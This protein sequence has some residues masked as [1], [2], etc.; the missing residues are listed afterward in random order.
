MSEHGKVFLDTNILVYSQD[1]HSRSKQRRARTLLRDVQDGGNGVI[2]TQVLQE[3]FVTATRKLEI[4]PIVAKGMLHSLN[5]LELVTVDADLIGEAAD[6]SIL[7]LL[8]F[9]DA[10]IVVSAERAHCA[11]LWTEDLNDGQQ[12]RGVHVRNPFTA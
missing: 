6:C 4:D 11:E 10:L 7:N 8:S 12:I 1:G 2:S 3:F 5:A 9:R